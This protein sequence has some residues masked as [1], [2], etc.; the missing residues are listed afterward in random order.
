[1]TPERPWELDI[2]HYDDSDHDTDD[3]TD[4][5]HDDDDDTGD[6]SDHK[7]GSYTAW[8]APRTSVNSDR[9]APKHT[10]R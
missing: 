3:D 1:M 9:Q 5:D 4:D 8:N 6:D 7:N 2:H 10:A